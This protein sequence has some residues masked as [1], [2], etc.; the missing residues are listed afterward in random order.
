MCDRKLNSL[1]ITIIK[2]CSYLLVTEAI[3]SG[4]MARKF[5]KHSLY[6]LDVINHRGRQSGCTAFSE[7]CSQGVSGVIQYCPT[8]FYYLSHLSQMRRVNWVWRGKLLHGRCLF[9]EMA[10]GFSERRGFSLKTKQKK[11]VLR[12][13]RAVYLPEY[14]HFKRKSFINTQPETATS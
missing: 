2:Q 4:Q 8:S 14:S 11:Q 10:T 7:N 1:L 13:R 9:F 12:D 6:M 5:H 3:F